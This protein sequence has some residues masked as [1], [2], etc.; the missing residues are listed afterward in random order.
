MEQNCGNHV[1]RFDILT[2]IQTALNVD[3]SASWLAKKKG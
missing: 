1:I 2:V 3:L